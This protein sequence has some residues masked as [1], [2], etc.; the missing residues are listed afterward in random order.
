MKAPTKDQLHPRNKNRE[1]YDL[2]ALE[3]LEP[4][5]SPFISKN[6][7]GNLSVDY[8][9]P[10][11][12]KLLNKGILKHYYELEFWEFPDHHLCPAVP[13]R[14]DYLHY[15]ADLIGDEKKE[16]GRNLRCLDVGTGASLIYPIIGVQE[17]NWSFVA[18]DID[19]NTI[20]IAKQIVNQNSTLKG[21]IGCVLQPN[22][23]AFFE[24]IIQLQINKAKYLT[25]AILIYIRLGIFLL[26]SLRCLLQYALIFLK[27]QVFICRRRTFY[28]I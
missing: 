20:Q 17:Y 22:V 5:L 15:V 2:D 9:D 27:L 10:K 3:K 1:L 28:S 12:I 6:E 8:S 25:Y 13:G 4:E 23:Y 24:N 14:A 11:A 7:F 19:P 18:T 26:Q 21:K 16:K